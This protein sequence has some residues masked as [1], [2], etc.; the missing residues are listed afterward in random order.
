M[1]KVPCCYGF[2]HLVETLPGVVWKAPV[3]RPFRAEWL[4]LWGDDTAELTSLSV[5]LDEHLVQRMPFAVMRRPIT[6]EQ[7]LTAVERKPGAP[8]EVTSTSVLLAGARIRPD[9]ARDHGRPSVEIRGALVAE[10]LSVIA[11]GN[12]RGVVMVGWELREPPPLPN[13]NEP[14]N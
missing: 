11:K 4:W 3:A 12:V 9:M 6:P 5:A 10:E 8:I 7:F 1:L 2:V 14:V 13:P